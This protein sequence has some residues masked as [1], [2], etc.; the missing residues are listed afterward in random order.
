M[1]PVIFNPASNFNLPTGLAVDTAGCLYVVDSGSQRVL[2]FNRAGNLIFE[3]GKFGTQEGN[4]NFCEDK[5]TVC[6]IAVDRHGNVFVVDKG[7]YRIQK[8]DHSGNFLL[9]WGSRGTADSQFVRAIYVAVDVHGCVFVT[10]DRN[11]VI[12]KFD[13][14]GRFLL[15]WGSQ[16]NKDGQFNHATAIAADSRGDI[17]ISDYENDRVQKFD[18]HGCFLTSWGMGE[19]EAQARLRLLL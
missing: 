7:N 13:N 6:G 8:F 15:K 9:A 1:K 18:N 10:D 3:W 5:G 11:P 4:F 17:Y 19:T 14:N 12:Q 2:K 16:G